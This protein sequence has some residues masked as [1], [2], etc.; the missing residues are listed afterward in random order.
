M[1]KLNTETYLPTARVGKQILS[2]LTAEA[3]RQQRTR[4]AVVRFAL[5][6]YLYGADVPMPATRDNGSPTPADGKG[7]A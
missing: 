3:E 2:D 4:A 5:E 6:H 1:A 7:A